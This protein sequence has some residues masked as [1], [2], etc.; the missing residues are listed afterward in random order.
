MTRSVLSQSAPPHRDA[1][2]SQQAAVMMQSITVWLWTALLAYG[3]YAL[4]R[5]QEALLQG[6]VRSLHPEV[7][8]KLHMLSS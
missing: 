8:Q 4:D 1:R 3:A 2:A 6:M 5:H 7:P